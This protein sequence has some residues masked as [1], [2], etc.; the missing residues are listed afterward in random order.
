MKFSHA[1]ALFLAP[2][3][4]ALILVLVFHDELMG[5]TALDKAKWPVPQASE[6]IDGVVHIAYNEKWI[7]ALF[8]N[9]RIACP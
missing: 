3:I 1:V 5:Y 9:R 7:P 8:D 2:L 6:C 4:A